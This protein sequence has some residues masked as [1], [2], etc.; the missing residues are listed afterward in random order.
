MK[1]TQSRRSPAGLTLIELLVVITIGTLMVSI[2]LPGL[3]QVRCRNRTHL[4][5][6][7]LRV[8]GNAVRAYA[9]DYN[10]NLPYA[11]G[12]ALPKTYPTR[13][14][15]QGSIATSLRERLAR[16]MHGTSAF[17]C[18]NDRGVPGFGTE[19]TKASR[20]FGSS[21]LWNDGLERDSQ[22]TARLSVNGA[23]L[24]SIKNPS[25]TPM[26][27]DYSA[28]WHQ[29][30]VRDGIRLAMAGRLNVVYVDGHVRENQPAISSEGVT[31]T[32]V[33]SQTQP[34]A[35]VTIR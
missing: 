20:L 21:Y 28:D 8:L 23:A 13:K 17:E 25:H 30:L 12:S 6:S 14:F 22:G 3:S 19:C 15:P 4:C 34:T 27:W 24:S 1:D 9:K 26:C 5:A 10:G 7:N 16:Y 33:Q 35:G 29:E 18:P 2:L 32:S 31:R 11:E